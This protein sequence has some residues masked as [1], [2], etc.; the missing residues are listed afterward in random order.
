MARYLTD[1]VKYNWVL[2][3]L[4]THVLCYMKSWMTIDEL[5]KTELDYLMNR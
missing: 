5:M 1:Q 2:K 3:K 4:A